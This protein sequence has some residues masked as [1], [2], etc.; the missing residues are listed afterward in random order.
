MNPIDII[1]SQTKARKAAL[2]LQV[3][4]VV[5][6]SEESELFS[7]G[8]RS[9]TFP[10]APLIRKEKQQKFKPE[11]ASSSERKSPLLDVDSLARIDIRKVSSTVPPETALSSFSSDKKHTRTLKKDKIKSPNA[12]KFVSKSSAE[13]KEINTEVDD[14]VK[15][16]ELEIE[17]LRLQIENQKLL[18]EKQSSKLHQVQD[19]ET[20]KWH[21][22]IENQLQAI[23]E[24]Q[25]IPLSSIRKKLSIIREQN[26]QEKEER[27]LREVEKLVKKEQDRIREAQRREVFQNELRARY[28]AMVDRTNRV[29]SLVASKMR[30]EHERELMFVERIKQQE[31]DQSALWN[32]SSTHSCQTSAKNSTGV[33]SQWRSDW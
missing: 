27:R 14:L 4:S 17:K 32:L 31:I 1:L 9:P 23:E 25:K 19:L 18:L 7:E 15:Q 28:E 13:T 10:V 5:S 33:W 3:P 29:N 12:V 2:N 30:T 24:A 16:Y 26:L 6:E 8:N 20:S 21:N 11:E 22:K